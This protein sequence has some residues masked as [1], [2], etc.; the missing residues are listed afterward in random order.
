VTGDRLVRR[1]VAAWMLLALGG[2]GLHPIYARPAGGRPT[3]SAQLGAV[4]VDRIPERA[5]QMLQLALQQ[6][7]EGSGTGQ[8]K[9]YD[10]SVQLGL[11]G[12]AA[13]YQPDTSITFVR[14]IGTAHYSL[15]AD[16]PQRRTLISGT[17]RS[18]DGEN[19]FQNQ[20]FAADLESEAVEQRL[21]D[22]L[23]DQIVLRLAA[24]F[25]QQRSAAR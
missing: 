15:T 14:F 8:T 22:T 2:C 24:Y 7:L 23:A 19:I 1:Q 4:T 12:E 3:A 21:A 25:D 11:E 10:L 9:R 18:V 17:A 20:F 16:E 6:R 13:G 5:G